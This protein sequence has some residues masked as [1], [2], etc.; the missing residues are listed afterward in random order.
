MSIKDQ[1]IQVVISNFEIGAGKIG[2]AQGPMALLDALKPLGIAFDSPMVLN[3]NEG[4]VSDLHTPHCKH[5]LEIEKAANTLNYA[6]EEQ[7]IKGCFPLILSGDHSNAIGGIS[8]VKNAFPDKRIGVI[9]VDAH[10]DL[11]SPYTTPSGNM[12]GMPLAALSNNDNLKFQKNQISA[13]ETEAW[14]RLKTIG[15]Q[16]ISPKIEVSDLVFIGIRDAEKEEW[17]LI[18]DHGIKTFE[19]DQIK[20][21]GI[22]YAIN[23]A[24]KHLEHCDLLYVSFDVDSLDPTVSVGT[25]TT[26]PEG[27]SV[28]EAES[29]FKSLLNHPKLAAFEITEINPSLDEGAS[30]MA[31]VVASLLQFGLK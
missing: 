31:N 3:T 26:S 7:L 24:I 6:I 12:H 8:G 25:G 5:I 29:V 19:P 4:G 1:K 17:G 30:K 16:S 23:H 13:L 15:K 18:E 21:H 28:L 10:A 22:Y 9:W 11:H 27:L 14:N 20:T 2:S